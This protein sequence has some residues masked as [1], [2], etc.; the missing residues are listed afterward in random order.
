MTDTR[1]EEFAAQL[2]ANVERWKAG[3]AVPGADGWSPEATAWAAAAGMTSATDA[4]RMM[5]N[6]RAS[7]ALPLKAFIAQL[8]AGAEPL[9]GTRDDMLTPL[10]V[11]H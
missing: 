10:A 9:I 1:T 2:G 6:H 5:L 3:R 4:Q 8:V 11:S 7:F